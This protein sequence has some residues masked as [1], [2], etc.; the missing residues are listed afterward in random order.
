M[1]IGDHPCIVWQAAD[2]AARCG[3]YL[4]AGSAQATRF[5]PCNFQREVA[6]HDHLQGVCDWQR[7]PTHDS[8]A[9]LVA[10]ATSNADIGSYRR[11]TDMQAW[12]DGYVTDIEYS[13]GF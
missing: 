13:D 4:A 2:S 3:K 11:T 10:Y 12:G 1:L 8:M 6:R 9:L 5:R 7:T